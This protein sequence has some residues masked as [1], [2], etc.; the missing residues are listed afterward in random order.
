MKTIGGE[1]AKG[2]QRKRAAAV[3]VRFSLLPTFRLQTLASITAKLGELIYQRLYGMRMIECQLL[4]V[5]QAYEPVSLR[6]ACVE[7]D[8]D[9]S[10]GSRLVARNVQAGL[11]DR[12]DDPADQRSFYLML[13]AAGREL[14]ARINAVAVQRNHDWMAGLVPQAQGEFLQQIDVQIAHTRALLEQELKRQRRAPPPTPSHERG[15]SGARETAPMLVE[16]RSLQAMH[17]LLGELL[18]QNGGARG[19]GADG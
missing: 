6:R 7:L 12:R 10:L 8:I 1:H 5:V 14:V 19:P 4:G 16:R 11:L 18:E 2:A 13:S 17:Q 15:D 9:K 3:P